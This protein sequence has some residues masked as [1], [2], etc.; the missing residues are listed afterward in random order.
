MH[1]IP[2]EN[3]IFLPSI[4]MGKI[5]FLFLLCEWGLEVWG[6]LV[7][8]SITDPVPFGGADTVSK[9]GHEDCSFQRKAWG[10]LC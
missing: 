10:R 5:S 4:V 8:V 1:C 6:G 7:A 9:Y 2:E 3:F